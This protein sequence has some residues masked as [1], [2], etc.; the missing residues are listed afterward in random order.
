MDLA[1]RL[2]RLGYSPGPLPPTPP[3][4]VPG[5]GIDEVVEGE[6]RETAYGPCFVGRSTYPGQHEHGGVRLEHVFDLSGIGLR[7]I[8]RSAELER[9]DFE[10]VAF[11]DTETTGLAGGTGTYVFL[12]G[13]GHFAEG[14]FTVEQFFLREYGEERAML[15]ALAA[16]LARFTAIVTFNGKAFD[17][18]L[19]QTRFGMHRHP[20]PQA[21]PLHLDLLFP[22]RRLWRERLGS[23]SLSAL[24][25]GVLGVKR[26]LDVPSWL[27]PNIYFQYVR[28]RDARPLRPVFAHN[29]QDV[30]SLLALTVR[31]ARHFAEPV[32]EAGH[33]L[34]LYSLGRVFES[35]QDWGDCLLCYEQSLAWGL[36][37]PQRE[38]ALTRLGLVY[39]RLAR[40]ENAERIWRSL[41]NRSGCL[42]LLPYVELAK[43]LEHRERN[44]GE[45]A[46]VVEQALAMLG[47]RGGDFWQR[48]RLDRERADL[49]HRRERL[50]RKASTEMQA[51]SKRPPGD[52]EAWREERA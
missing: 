37:A 24:E 42:G 19:L 11:L 49:E 9:L 36:P 25:E 38:A 12:V 2:R 46:V 17:W 8:G 15:A 13:L 6:W 3:P 10:H 34:D 16:R 18:P 23:C 51:V 33:P 5:G 41:V 32:S 40:L 21:E 39:K 44:Y 48:V 4:S 7:R 30:L 50:R 26:R 20:L 47:R 43:H 27:I 45:A 28:E 29:E 52:T 1:E 14:R 35:S 22:A 31:L